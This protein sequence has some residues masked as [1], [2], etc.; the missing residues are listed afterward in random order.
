V[1]VRVLGPLEV[2]EDDE[3]L[4]LGGLKQRALLAI[5]ALHAN[6]VVSS[7]RLIDELW[8]AE[9]PPTAAKSLQV[10]VSQLR[11]V[12]EPKRKSG[13]AGE[14]LLTQSPGYVLALDPDQLDVERFKRLYEEG[15]EALAKGDP[16]AAAAQLDEALTLWRGA[17]LADLT[18]A[19]FAQSE[20]SRLEE[21]RLA[22]L[23]DRIEAEIGCG[24]HTAVIG[25]LERMVSVEPLRE[26]PRRQLMLALYRSGRQAEA[27]EVYRDAHRSLVDE[28]GIEPGR[29]LR[30][31]QA[32]ILRQDPELDLRASA[33]EPSPVAVAAG[34]IAAETPSE[35]FVG[36]ESELAEFQAAFDE[37][38]A[39]R[40]SLFLIAGEP[41][42]GKSRLADEATSLAEARRAR[43]CWGRCWEAGGAPAYWP[44]VQ[45]LREYIRTADDERVRE[46]LE[47]GAA[48]IAQM[49]PE[50]HE[51]FPDLPP[52]PSLDPAGARFRL[53]DSTASFL[54]AVGETQPLVLM[55]DDLHAADEPSLLF[56]QFLARSLREAHVVVVGAYRDTEPRREALNEAIAEARREPI[57]RHIRL[58][59]LDEDEVAAVVELIGGTRPSDE[60]ARALYR[61]TEGN[62]LFVGELVR[63]LASEGRL[64]E[65]AG[66]TSA[67]RIPQGVRE[68]ID[69]RLRH[70]SGECKR[71]L[72]VAS[73]LGREFRLDALERVS[74]QPHERLLDLLDEAQAAR[75]VVDIPAGRGGLRFSHA[76]IRDSLYGD[77]ASGERLRLHRR[78]VESLEELYRTERDA[79]LAEL[80]YHAF[81]AA[82]GGDLDKA[83]HY[84][85]QAG[86]Q[87]VSL[88]AYEEAARL[89]R[90]GLD[91]LELK[92][93][94]DEDTR[95]EL[96]LALGDAIARGG[97]LPAAKEIFVRAADLARELDEPEH[98]ARAALGYGGRWVWFRAGKDQRLIPLLEDAIEALPAGDN[99]LQAMLLARL[100]GA[101]RDRPVPERRAALT[102]EAVEIARRL[103]DPRTLAYTVGGLYSAISW[104]RDVEAWLATASEVKQLADATGDKEQAFFGHFHFMG[105]LMVRGEIAAADAE[106]ESMTRLSEELRQPVEI[107][108]NW[109]AETMRETFA[110]RLERAEEVM[111]RA[112]ELGSRSQG[113][114]A[115][116]YYAM[117]LQAWALRREQG[118]LADVE[119][120]LERYLDDYPAIFV[121]RALLVSVHAELGRSDHARAELDRL[122]ADA[123][124]D[125]EQGMDWFLGASVL[126]TVCD[127]LRDGERAKP[128]YEVLLP[129]ADYNVF[130]MPEVALGS[131]SLPLGIL[132][133]TMSRWE[134][135]ERH[136][137]R[138][139]EMNSRMGVRPWVA[140][141]RHD[142]GRMLIR[143][144]AAGDE[145]RATELLEG[146]A[147]GYEELGMTAWTERAMAD[148]AGIADSAPTS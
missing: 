117:N 12:L 64:D 14:L 7:D 66:G 47:P 109:V 94:P 95:C 37:A 33:E 36:R 125:L 144:G 43:V 134:D 107:W 72:S 68:V 51:L 100:A 99:E 45:A 105:A 42:I 54:R 93:P 131:A 63:L 121:F 111:Q 53:F 102:R 49:L 19:S 126:A 137:E 41:G 71:L 50:L 46:Q 21:M 32:A 30:E 9:A 59:G 38:L 98:L 142:Y 104:P 13:E 5:L 82:P 76:L 101:L 27:L 112:A 6:E 58:G 61:E 34:S 148:L 81:E 92:A 116:Y 130:A 141:A 120:S 57:T 23:E 70:L 11:K 110:G 90:M 25:D 62:P 87:A 145:M 96:L 147:E 35:S 31:I 113:L 136:F 119:P 48:D 75:V 78:A 29:E 18:Y 39:G 133:T 69:H 97:D 55:L 135:A 129:Y 15:R 40:M 56:L 103:D 138:A 22:A 79:H 28:L 44:W 106:F 17:P 10:H 3:Q 132:A 128:L 114:D 52:P 20:I 85:T 91:A 122:A 108:I 123:F 67:L 26:R 65:A 77:L 88:V 60:L 89:Y 143:R 84:A 124:A 115:T 24:R 127:L 74:E 118:R 4:A 2:R 73:V 146:A 140:H 16:E 8:G 80:A 139:L 1:E 83:I 86:D